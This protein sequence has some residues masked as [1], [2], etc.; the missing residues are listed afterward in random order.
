MFS[1][2]R[3]HTNNLFIYQY[4]LSPALAQLRFRIRKANRNLSTNFLSSV[5]IVGKIGSGGPNTRCKIGKKI[6]KRFTN[7]ELLVINQL[8]TTCSWLDLS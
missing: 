5:S 4:R 2:I 3:S 7:V 6:M 8:S 1:E